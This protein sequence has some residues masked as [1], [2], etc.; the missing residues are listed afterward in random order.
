MLTHIP[1][2]RYYEQSKVE[3]VRTQQ[4][5]DKVEELIN[6]PNFDSATGNPFTAEVGTYTGPF[7]FMYYTKDNVLH[8]V[9]ISKTGRVLRKVSK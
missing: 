6:D 4:Q 3:E 9:R 2:G 1:V 8:L 5:R 7:N